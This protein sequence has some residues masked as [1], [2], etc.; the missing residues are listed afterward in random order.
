TALAV[1]AARAMESARPTPLITDRYAGAFVAA[2]EQGGARLPLPS[3]WPPDVADMAAAT[4]IDATQ[5]RQLW[6]GL[7]DYL[8][9]RSRYFDRFLTSAC[10]AAGIRQV[11]V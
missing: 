3:N 1:A 5:L 10:H 11:V 4:G 9:V 6:E 8:A 7:T 2:A